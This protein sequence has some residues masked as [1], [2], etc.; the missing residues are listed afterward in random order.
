MLT[1]EEAALELG[2]KTLKTL[3]L[4]QPNLFNRP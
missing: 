3:P 2:L 1:V 4:K